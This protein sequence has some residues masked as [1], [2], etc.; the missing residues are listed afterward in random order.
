M[1]KCFTWFPFCN[2]GEPNI[3]QN[4]GDFTR[5][6]GFLFEDIFGEC[7]SMTFGDSFLDGVFLKPPSVDFLIYHSSIIQ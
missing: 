7:Y 5:M 1:S 2:L 3:Y 4:L 6:W